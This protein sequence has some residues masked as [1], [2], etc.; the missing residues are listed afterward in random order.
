MRV[1]SNSNIRKN[2]YPKSLTWWYLEWFFNKA[3]ESLLK[4]FSSS[5]K[6]QNQLSLCCTVWNKPKV[7]QSIFYIKWHLKWVWYY[8][9]STKFLASK[10]AKWLYKRIRIHQTILFFNSIVNILH[11][12]YKIKKF[13][14]F[15]EYWG[16]GFPKCSMGI[17]GCFCSNCQ[18]WFQKF[19]WV[20]LKTDWDLEALW[21]P[22][23]WW[24][25]G[26]KEGEK[27]LQISA[28]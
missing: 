9:C 25:G 13:G 2:S 19:I 8:Q 12:L 17:F 23:F 7:F 1:I 24:G 14:F 6:L 28:F 15:S 4:S 5:F 18:A 10:K 3:M 22:E 20:A 21:A 26:G 11:K 27:P 16:F